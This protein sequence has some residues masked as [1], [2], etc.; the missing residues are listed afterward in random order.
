MSR[1]RP[2][3]NFVDLSAE[4]GVEQV[5]VDRL[6]SI[7]GTTDPQVQTLNQQNAAHFGVVRA[8]GHEIGDAEAFEPYDDLSVEL[9]DDIDKNLAA[10]ATDARGLAIAN[11]V[12]TVGAA[13]RRDLPGPA[14]LPHAAEPDPPG[15]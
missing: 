7:L 8:G 1:S 15:A 3:I 5:I 13:D 6:G 9:L 12:I 14:G 11:A 10:A 4:L 2:T